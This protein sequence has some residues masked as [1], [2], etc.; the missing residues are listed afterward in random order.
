MRGNFSIKQEA[1]GLKFA[2]E[3]FLVKDAFK[4]KRQSPITPVFTAT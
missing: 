1:Q 4:K 3:G 2:Q